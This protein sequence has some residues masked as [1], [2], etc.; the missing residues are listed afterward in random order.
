MSSFSQCDCSSSSQHSRFV[1][2]LIRSGKV[3]TLSNHR[4]VVADDPWQC[5]F[6][7][8]EQGAQRRHRNGRSDRVDVKPNPA[9]WEFELT[10]NVFEELRSGWMTNQTDLAVPRSDAEQALPGKLLNFRLQ[11]IGMQIRI[12]DVEKKWSR[13]L[14]EVQA[15]TRKQQIMQ[16]ED[17]DEDAHGCRRV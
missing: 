15:V 10:G 16:L 12:D 13:P 17:R 6:V 5:W 7:R 9:S 14:E 3:H 8:H 11:F 1:S 4:C 2:S